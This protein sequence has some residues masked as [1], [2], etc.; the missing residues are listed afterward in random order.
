M[1]HVITK[2][3]M[4][5][6]YAQCVDVCPVDCIYPGLY[7]QTLYMVIDPKICINCEA[8]LQVCPIG[9]IVDSPEK[10]PNA[11]MLNKYLAPEFRGNPAIPPRNPRSKPT[12][13]ENSLIYSSK[14][15][16]IS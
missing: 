15:Y 5:E 2:K 14:S 8:C 7:Q 6:V 16:K 13:K 10:D 3:C 4:K 9:A 12:R 11:A 1:P